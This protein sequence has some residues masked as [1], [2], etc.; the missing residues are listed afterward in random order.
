L[1]NGDGTFRAAVNYPAGTYPRELAVADVNGDGILD[2]I[3]GNEGDPFNSGQD[4]G[5]AILLGNGD[6]TFQAAR[7]Y[8]LGFYV[9][10]VAVGDFNG[11]GIQDLVATTTGDLATGQGGSVSVLLGNGDGTFQEA[12]NYAAGKAPF[13]VAV[14]DFNRDGVLDLAVANYGSKNVSVLMGKGDGTFQAA[15]NYPAGSNPGFV[16]VRDF[17]GDAIPDIVVLG[18]DGVRVLFGN[19]DSTFQAN[20]ISYVAG[21]SAYGVVVGEFNGDGLPDLAVTNNGLNNVSILINDGKWSP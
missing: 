12:V 17:N 6:G 9:L 16:A 2:L 13:S 7:Q 21:A 8:A 11:D 18:A 1:G 10:S 4:S 15:V 3:V 20:A 14:G 19:G 5:V